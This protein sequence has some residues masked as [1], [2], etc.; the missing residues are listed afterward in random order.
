MNESNQLPR[1]FQWIASDKK[2]QIVFLD[3]IVAEDGIA[4]LCFKDGSRMNEAFV[5]ALNQ[6]DLTGTYYMAEIEHPTNCWQFQEEWIGREEEKW[7]LNADGE[8]VW[9]LKAGIHVWLCRVL[10][11]WLSPLSRMVS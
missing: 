10:K 1:Y 3:K 2:G 5:A 11:I 7:E 8:R 6:K 4:F 9:S